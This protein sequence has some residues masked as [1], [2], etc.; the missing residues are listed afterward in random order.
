MPADAGNPFY[1]KNSA[2]WHPFPATYSL[3]G[4]AELRR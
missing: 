3:L 1:G 4:E 2:W